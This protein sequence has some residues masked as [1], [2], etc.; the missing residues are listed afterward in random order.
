MNKNHS[1]S[2]HNSSLLYIVRIVAAEAVLMG[3][4]LVFLSVYPFSTQD[5]F[6]FIQSLAVIVFLLLSG[7]FS[8]HSISKSYEAPYTYGAYMKKHFI[9]IFSY[10]LVALIF[11]TITDAIVLCVNEDVYRYSSTFNFSTFMK[12]ALM[13]P[14]EYAPYASAR[15]L[16][17]L[18]IE[19][20]L[21]I[22]F[23]FLSLVFVKR[24]KAHKLEFIDVLCVIFLAVPLIFNPLPQNQVFATVLAFVFGVIIHRVYKYISFSTVTLAVTTVLFIAVILNLKNAYHVIIVILLAFLLL[25]ILS[26]GDTK[27][28]IIKDKKILVFFSGC[29]YPLYLVHYTVIEFFL[30]LFPDL[31]R[32][33]HFVLSFVLSHIIAIGI[34]I[35]VNYFILKTAKKQS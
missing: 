18:Y 22:I 30:K 4:L 20:W 15:P 35:F 2:K 10:L 17:T 6:P 7:F 25:Q 14:F 32:T 26:I 8:D 9:R 31:P 21:Y 34:Y 1:L 27:E 13:L 28:S 19:W 23:G 29:T 12:N 16:W 3:H 24:L 33:I 5:Y 11:V